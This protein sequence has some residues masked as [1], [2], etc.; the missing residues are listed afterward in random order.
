MAANKP[1]TIQKRVDEGFYSDN[2]KKGFTTTCVKYFDGD[3]TATGIWLR[4]QGKIRERRKPWET[5]WGNMP[6]IEKE[7]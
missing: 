7:D 5:Y 3:R 2:G 4:S 1:E 6:A